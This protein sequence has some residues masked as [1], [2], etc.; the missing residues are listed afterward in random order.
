MNLITEFEIKHDVNLR[1]ISK[2]ITQLNKIPEIMER[3][4]LTGTLDIFINNFKQVND[5]YI[6]IETNEVVSPKV[7]K[8]TNEIIRYCFMNIFD[9]ELESALYE[10]NKKL[11]NYLFNYR[12][13]HYNV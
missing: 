6:D 3:Y 7:H 10:S 12:K 11:T 5:E 1:F 13:E 4:R 8:D 9:T 2:L